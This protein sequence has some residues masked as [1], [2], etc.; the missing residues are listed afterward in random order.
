MNL[1]QI[2]VRIAAMPIES[3][4]HKGGKFDMEVFR[5]L[6]EFR[7]LEYAHSTL[8]QIDGGTG[9]SRAAFIFSSGKVLKIA[10]EKKWGG[11]LD[12]GVAQNEYEVDL[13]TSPK[14][15]PI[16]AKIFD[17]AADFVWIISEL[18]RPIKDWA[19]WKSLTGSDLKE[20]LNLAESASWDGVHEVNDEWIDNYYQE[21]SSN[22]NRTQVDRSQDPV[23]PDMINL[24]ISVLDQGLAVSDLSRSG[25]W[26]KTSSGRV[27]LLDYGASE[28]ILEEHYEEHSESE[29]TSY[30]GD[31]EGEDQNA[32]EV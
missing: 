18:V 19:E 25:Q 12:A 10:K 30:D 13:Y 28:S 8:Q 7:M 9:S 5:D 32:D 2:A 3:I 15:K 21:L 11:D 6:E 31:Q 22:H 26:G 27:V 23:S 1:L 14:T 4:R 29:L 17:S 20:A 24:I 16:V